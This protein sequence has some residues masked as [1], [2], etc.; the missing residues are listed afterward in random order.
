MMTSPARHTT[1]RDVYRGMLACHTGGSIGPIDVSPNVLP[2]LPRCNDCFNEEAAL[3]LFV[4]SRPSGTNTPPT[5]HSTGTRESICRVTWP[6]CSGPSF[7]ATRTTISA[8]VSARRY[9]SSICST[10]KVTQPS[11]VRPSGRTCLTEWMC[12]APTAKAVPMSEDSTCTNDSSLMQ[13]RRSRLIF[14]R[15]R[16]LPGGAGSR[17]D[18]GPNSAADGIYTRRRHPATHHARGDAMPA[19]RG[20]VPVRPAGWGVASV[21]ELVA[22]SATND[23]R[24][25][26][27]DQ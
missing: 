4:A 23:G 24:K 14:I 19:S 6:Q 22:R 9:G 25:Y 11:P 16:N 20:N 1:K 10:S 5:S 18:D 26:M 2:L 3:R 17:A 15:S 21:G 7:S 12:S 27:Y 8:N 13:Q